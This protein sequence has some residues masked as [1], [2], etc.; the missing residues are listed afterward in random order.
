MP[1]SACARYSRSG[2]MIDCPDT[3][4]L[5]ALSAAL[6]WNAEE[7]VA[8]IASCEPC[9]ERMRLLDSLHA[10]MAE[11]MPV[12]AGLQAAILD[13]LEGEAGEARA[14]APSPPRSGRLRALPA[15]VLPLAS[16]TAFV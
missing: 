15:L 6:G 1:S 11:E 4:A 9:R 10:V 8:H 7:R 12:P 5:A 2:K 16:L 3:D 13:A 14:A